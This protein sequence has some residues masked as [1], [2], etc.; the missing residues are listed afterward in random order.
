MRELGLTQD[1]ANVNVYVVTLGAGLEDLRGK[2]FPVH[3]VCWGMAWR[4]RV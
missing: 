1:S 4:S 3:A 2:K